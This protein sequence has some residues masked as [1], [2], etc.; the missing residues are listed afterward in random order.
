MTPFKGEASAKGLSPMTVGGTSGDWSST[1]AGSGITW[2]EGSFPVAQFNDPNDEDFSIQLN[3]N[4]FT[5]PQCG[6]ISGC[7]GWQQFAYEKLNGD[8]NIFI[9]YW[10]IGYNTAG[11]GCPFD[12]KQSPSNAND[13]YSNGN[14]TATGNVLLTDLS[15]VVITAQQSELGGEVLNDVV[16]WDGVDNMWAATDDYNY[17]S[18]NGNA[19]Q[20]PTA[21]WL[22]AEFNVF[23]A[24][25]GA[26]LNINGES[27][28]VVQLL[29]SN[30]SI[31]QASCGPNLVYL[32]AESNSLFRNGSCCSFGGAEPGIQ[33]TESS[34]AGAPP[35]P[36]PP[37]AQ[38]VAGGSVAV[39]QQFGAG[40]QTDLFTFDTNNLL[41][42]STVSGNEPWTLPIELPAGVGSFLPGQPLVATQDFAATTPQ[43]DVFAVDGNGIMHFFWV[44][45]S[46]QWD[47]LALDGLNGGGYVAGSHLAASQQFGT[48]VPQTDVFAVDK[49]GALSVLWENSINNGYAEISAQG[50]SS[51]PPTSG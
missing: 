17:L 2:A 42:V 24:A 12:W 31:G 28:I 46:G 35:H 13:C 21:Q 5:P 47:M 50:L 18:L 44:Q 6:S 19:A 16:M 9:Q 22:T 23:G 38:P 34:N 33:F 43:T 41:T 8:E 48:S 11:Q 45:N 1:V 14:M 51:D 4:Q 10:L 49:Y 30:G 40:D 26:E 7:K 3:T 29:T 25:N 37:A 39:S 15:N 32:T 36:C 20:W 27:T